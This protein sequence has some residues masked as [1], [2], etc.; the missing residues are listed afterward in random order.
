MPPTPRVPSRARAF[1]GSLTMVILPMPGRPRCRWSVAMACFWKSAGDRGRSASPSIPRMHFRTSDRWSK[2]D[3][4]PKPRCHLRFGLRRRPNSVRGGV[5]FPPASSPRAQKPWR[6]ALDAGPTVTVWAS[7]APLSAGRADRS[8][9]G[10]AAMRPGDRLGTLHSTQRWWAK[11]F[12]QRDLPDRGRVRETVR[13]CLH[14]NALT[15]WRAA[16]GP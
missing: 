13:R 4:I 10:A 3:E 7:P 8:G 1:V 6:V 2:S 16:V 15:D 9:T 12:G 11:H 14:R 5:R